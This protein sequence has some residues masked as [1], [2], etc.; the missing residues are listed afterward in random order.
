M[1]TLK[2]RVKQLIAYLMINFLNLW[3]HLYSLFFR[4]AIYFLIWGVFSLL[5]KYL[6]LWV[7]WPSVLIG[8]K[9]IPMHDILSNLLNIWLLSGIIAILFVYFLHLSTSLRNALR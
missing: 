1:E 3:V 6:N 7:F 8:E 9:Y 4:I 5:L 2:L